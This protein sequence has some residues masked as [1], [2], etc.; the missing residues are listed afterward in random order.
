MLNFGNFS[1]RF[2]V[3]LCFFVFVPMIAASV[4]VLTGVSYHSVSEAKNDV[5]VVSCP[6]RSC[7]DYVRFPRKPEKRP[8]VRSVKSDGGGLG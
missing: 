3:L 7:R 1:E 5:K 6:C 8:A 2:K 4:L